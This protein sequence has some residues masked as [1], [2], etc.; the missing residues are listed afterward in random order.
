MIGITKACP[1]PNDEWKL[2]EHLYLSEEGF[3]ARIRE[4]NILPPVISQWDD[5]RFNREDPFFGGQKVDQLYIE[6]AHEI[7][8]RYVTPATKAASGALTEVLLR[9]IDH[10]NTRGTAGLEE[11]CAKWLKQAADELDRTIRWGEFE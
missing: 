2:I 10:V 5:E 6:L 1:R 8:E 4:T 11:A 7:P 3:E 9:A